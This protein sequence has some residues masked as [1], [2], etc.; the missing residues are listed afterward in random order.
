VVAESHAPTLSHTL[1]TSS[2]GSATPHTNRRAKD[3]SSLL[4]VI[5]L[6]FSNNEQSKVKKKV[7]DTASKKVA[8][9]VGKLIAVQTIRVAAVELPHSTIRDIVQSFD[10]VNATTIKDRYP[11]QK[12]KVSQVLDFLQQWKIKQVPFVVVY[13][14]KDET[15][16]LLNFY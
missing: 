6:G 13:S 8:P 4:D 9:T 3:S 2:I 11:K 14:I 7:C 15:F 12:D 5:L 10:R 16:E 1:S